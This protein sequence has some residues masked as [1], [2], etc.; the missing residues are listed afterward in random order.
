MNKIDSHVAKAYVAQKELET[1]SQTKVDE[2]VNA[3][4]DLVYDNA[5]ELAQLAVDETRMG[6]YHDKVSKCQNKS[7]NI[8]TALMHKKSRGILRHLR[9]E[10]LVEIAKPMGVV[11][12]VTPTTNPVVTAMCN[13]MFAIKGGN[14]II[15]APHP[16][17]QKTNLVLCEMIRNKIS[18]L[19]GNPDIY[20]CIVPNG[21]D[22]TNELMQKC[23]I[24]IATGGMAMVKSAYSSG[25]P[26]F[27]VGAGN[28]QVLIDRL[29]NEDSALNID[30][31]KMVKMIIAGRSFDN[32]IICACEQSLIM[33]SDDKDEI[34]TEFESEK[35]LYI[36]DA[37]EV[38]RFADMLF[39][40]GAINKD[41][42]GQSAVNIAQKLGYLQIDDSQMNFDEFNNSLPPNQKVIHKDCKVIILEG[43][44]ERLRKEK[45]FPVLACY[46][47]SDW[48][49]AIN[50]ARTNL[51][52]EGIGHSVSLHSN[53]SEHIERAGIELPVS[54]ILV[55]QTSATNVGGSPLNSLNPTTTI[56]CGSWGNNSISENLFYTHLFNVSRIAYSLE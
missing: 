38:S 21:L 52:C 54:R 32:G 1:Y 49:Q 33:H 39:P 45:M 48:G 55:N 18:Q 10:G 37:Q 14:S 28:V 36:K 41:F 19:D 25:K 6:N 3:I 22:E 27:G 2:I 35:C 47:Y 46:T 23:D 50:I 34:M 31:K 43:T 16:R 20:Q 24:V 30:L 8:K 29:K 5:H 15:I 26:S 53:I 9:D 4:A 17:A 11:A 12:S 42:V 56:G 44:D 51:E 40:G 7:S 13:A